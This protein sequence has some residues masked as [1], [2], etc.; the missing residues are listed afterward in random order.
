M[1]NITKS[2]DNIIN[3]MNNIKIDTNTA[4]IYSRISTSKQQDGTSLEMQQTLC[5]DYCNLMKFNII[6]IKKEICSAT[7]MIIQKELNNIINNNSNINLIILDS[8]RLSRNIK[9]FILLLD[10]CNKKNIIIHFVK[11]IIISNNSHD[12]K[13]MFSNVY[14]AEIESKTLSERIKRSINHRKRM[15]TYLPSIPPFGHII[16]DKKLCH[17]EKEQDI[18]HLINKLFWGSDTFSINQL[19][20]KITGVQDE[21]CDL[22]DNDEILEV[23]Y[24]NLRIIDIVHFLNNLEIKCRKRK[25]NSNSVSKLIKKKINLY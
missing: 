19:L 5:T 18:I 14:D 22:Y 13:I 2:L 8:S 17:N 10:I 12:I 1:T 6:S 9:D 15:K 4:I 23:K 21:I 3:N 7:S 16:K 11:N 20:F 24:G 25:W